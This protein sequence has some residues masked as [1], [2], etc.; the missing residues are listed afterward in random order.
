M[1]PF[2]SQGNIVAMSILKRVITGYLTRYNINITK[3]VLY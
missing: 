1:N 2:L 3:L